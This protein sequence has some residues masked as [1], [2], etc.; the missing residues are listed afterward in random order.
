[1][2][3]FHCNKLFEKLGVATISEAILNARV[4]KLI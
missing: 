2:V 3:K 4:D 1:M